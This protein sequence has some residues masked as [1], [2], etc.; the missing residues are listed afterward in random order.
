MTASPL[1][2]RRRRRPRRGSL[3]R[4][5]SSQ[6]YRSAFLV[7][8]LPLLLAAFTITRPGALAQPLLPPAFDAQATLQLAQE[9]SST[10]PDRAP[11]TAGALRAAKWFSQQLAPFGLPTVTDSWTQKL[12]SGRTAELQNVIAFA[13]S[14]PANPTDVIV[15]M[16]HRDDTGAGPGADDN[17]TGTAALIEL[18]PAVCAGAAGELW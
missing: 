15:V 12:P 6:L 7:C 18:A 13:P 17:A 8:S 11:G 14:A 4:P 3:E 2:V 10:Y 5:V 9:L 16:A 1:T